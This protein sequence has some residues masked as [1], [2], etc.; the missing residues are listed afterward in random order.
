MFC[1]S[2]FTSAA[3]G[4]SLSSFVLLLPYMPLLLS[5]LRKLLLSPLLHSDK[6]E[7]ECSVVTADL[8]G[9]SVASIGDRRGLGAFKSILLN[10][11]ITYLTS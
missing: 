6:L 2:T 1:S 9:I 10:K 8:L 7:V 3:V 4:V 5:L 11:S